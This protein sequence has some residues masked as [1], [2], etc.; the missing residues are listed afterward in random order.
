MSYHTFIHS[1][2]NGYEIKEEGKV[3]E[4]VFLSLSL[5]LDSSTTWKGHI[6][7][8]GFL[9][10]GFR[11]F[12]VQLMRLFCLFT[13]YENIA[14]SNLNSVLYENSTK[15][16]IG[17]TSH[18]LN[19]LYKHKRNMSIGVYGYAYHTHVYMYVYMNECIYACVC[20]CTYVYTYTLTHANIHHT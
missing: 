15:T 18:L 1:Y 17:K 2:F 4:N 20:V 6:K 13:F 11:H 16:M 10:D 3:L 9:E 7:L 19:S 5:K 14:V 12:G 8:M